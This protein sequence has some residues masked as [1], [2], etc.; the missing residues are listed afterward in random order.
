MIHYFSYGRYAEENYLRDTL[1]TLGITDA[2]FT[3]AGYLKDYRIQKLPEWLRQYDIHS[4]IVASP[5][6]TVRGFIVKIPL[7]YEIAVNT[8]I[9]CPIFMTKLNVEIKSSQSIL[10]CVTYTLAPRIADTL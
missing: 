10:N 8:W 2:E 5:G 3:G 4:T 1:R 9:L 6:D 7:V